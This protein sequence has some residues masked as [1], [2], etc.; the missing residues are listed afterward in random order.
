M[1]RQVLSNQVLLYLLLI[2]TGNVLAADAG[3]GARQLLAEMTRAMS[4]LNYQGTLALYRNGELETLKLYHAA[5]AGREQERLVSLN[6]PL[7]EVFR[8]SKQVKCVFLDTS[9]VIIDHRPS[10]RS[11][12]MD[13][14]N[15]LVA[16]EQFYSFSLG[17]PAVI[18]MMPARVVV[19][20]PRDNFRFTRKVWVGIKNKLPL[21]FELL[22]VRGNIL[23]QVVFIDLKV[24]DSLPIKELTTQHSSY[25]QRIKEFKPLAPEQ[26]KFVLKTIPAGFKT[27]FF[28]RRRLHPA[29]LPVDHFLLSDGFSSVSVYLEK[30]TEKN[31]KGQQNAGAVSS[32]YRMLDDYKITV[33]GEVPTRTLKY[34]ADGIEVKTPRSQ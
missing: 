17:E 22:N 26:A 12:L 4:Q 28:T 8:S 29:G 14:P 10:R 23:D 7:R 33:M 11:F 15:D 30:A 31:Q 21:K 3:N 20:I 19:I 27:V 6:S 9:K 5:K 18:A 13:V 25:A 34:I 1:D 32:Y 16:A 24:V 2:C